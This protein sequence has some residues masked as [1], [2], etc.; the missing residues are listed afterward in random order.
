[1]EEQQIWNNEGDKWPDYIPR[2]T[3]PH[4]AGIVGRMLSAQAN[5]FGQIG[6]DLV[7]PLEAVAGPDWQHQLMRGLGYAFAKH[8]IHDILAIQPASGPLHS[9]P[10]LVREHPDPKAELIEGSRM[11]MCWRIITE[12]VV[13]DSMPLPTKLFPLPDSQMWPQTHEPICEF[14]FE[15]VLT[16][17]LHVALAQ[18]MEVPENKQTYRTEGQ[19]FMDII[20]DEQ[21]RGFSNSGL[22]PNVV[23][24]HHSRDAQVDQHRAYSITLHRFPRDRM[25]MLHRGA[26]GF[27]G[28][29]AWVPY[30]I[31]FMPVAED[32]KIKGQPDGT[33]KRYSRGLAMAIRHK[34]VITNPESIRVAELHD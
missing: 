31:Q 9:L 21:Q 17:C 7:E 32:D 16:H 13:V 20:A 24:A 15:E 30:V 5:Y 8:Q 26:S 2:D 12:S 14:L 18:A 28:S 4:R 23:V 33:F 10:V 1:M 29:V 3:L 27:V 11:D 34:V 22:L 25:L 19:H 6:P